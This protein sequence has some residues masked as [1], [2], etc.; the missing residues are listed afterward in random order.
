[1]IDDILS[2]QQQQQYEEEVYCQ[3]SHL[4][5]SL[6][7]SGGLLFHQRPATEGTLAT[8]LARLLMLC[9][10][11]QS[12]R[13]QASRLV[14]CEQPDRPPHQ[15]SQ[16]MLQTSQSFRRHMYALLL[17]PIHLRRRVLR[18]VLYPASYTHEEVMSQPA[19]ESP[20]VTPPLLSQRTPQQPAANTPHH[21]SLRYPPLCNI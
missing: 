15:G 19:S 3:Q 18:T 5:F 12:L 17:F 7:S 10:H 14:A 21:S 8:R 4:S 20:A 9:H 1:M 2:Q 16:H 13:K 6:F 11:Q